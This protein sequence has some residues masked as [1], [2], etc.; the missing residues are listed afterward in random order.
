MTTLTSTRSLT[1]TLPAPDLRRRIRPSRE[2]LRVAAAMFAVGLIRG[3]LWR[4]GHANP[5]IR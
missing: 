2:Q 5:A 4:R 3:A 1:Q